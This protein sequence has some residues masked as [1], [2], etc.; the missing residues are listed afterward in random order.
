M[1]HEFKLLGEAGVTV[2]FELLDADKALSIEPLLASIFREVA[3]VCW[4]ARVGG[5]RTGS[6]GVGR[7]R[8]PTR[9]WASGFTAPRWNVLSGSE[10]RSA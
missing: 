7:E 4:V 8:C 1:L 9:R 2:D 3:V 5:L 10:V 6:P